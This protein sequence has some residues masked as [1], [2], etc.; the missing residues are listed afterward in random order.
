MAVS[1]SIGSNIFDVTVGLPLPWFVYNA[2]K[3]KSFKVRDIIIIII[4]IMMYII[5]YIIIHI[6]SH[7]TT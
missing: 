3:G 2:V 5:Y 7:I 6:I 1:S 4:I